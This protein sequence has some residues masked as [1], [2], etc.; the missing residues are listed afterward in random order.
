M[1]QGQ[2]HSQPSLVEELSFPDWTDSH[3][4]S[5]PS[6][7]TLVKKCSSG[8]RKA[9][10]VGWGSWWGLQELERLLVLQLLRRTHQ[11]PEAVTHVHGGSTSESLIFILEDSVPPWFSQVWLHF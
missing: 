7:F 11:V 10:R 3:L 5:H 1:A 9:V 4:V 2:E 6:Q 8:F